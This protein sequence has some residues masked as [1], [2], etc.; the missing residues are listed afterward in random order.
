MQA[1][2]VVMG[3]VNTMSHDLLFTKLIRGK[4]NKMSGSNELKKKPRIAGLLKLFI[5][6]HS[7]SL[8]CTWII[9]F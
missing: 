1:Q 9:Y 7:R 5:P 2:G 3:I 6:M 8:K 4:Q